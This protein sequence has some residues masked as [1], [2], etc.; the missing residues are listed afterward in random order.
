MPDYMAEL[1]K[2][3]TFVY[4]I[5]GLL[6][7]VL[8]FLQLPN[9]ISPE[10]SIKPI[11][12]SKFFAAM[13]NSLLQSRTYFLPSSILYQGETLLVDIENP[14]S[15]EQFINFQ[16]REIKF[17]PYQNRL[18]A[19]VALKINE[20]IGESEIKV[21]DELFSISVMKRDFSVIE[22]RPPKPLTPKLAA[23]RQAERKVTKQ[24]FAKVSSAVYFNSP[25]IA[26]LNRLIETS[27][28]GEHRVA[29]GYLSIHE[30]ID[31]RAGVGT[32]VRAINDGIVATAENYLFEGSFVI[33]DH[34][35]GI[36]SS[37][38]HL[39][40]LKVSAGEKIEKG[41]I[42]GLSGGSGLSSG[43][44]LHFGIKISGIP[45]DPMQFLSLW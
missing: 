12:E 20:S 3:K 43:P 17:F 22:I 42:I 4:I 10:Q 29:P 7:A 34:G 21:N 31:L 37:Y 33:L 6:V 23:R 30:G 44:H 27:P 25:F 35:L 41:Q 1:K 19:V 8:A 15:Q 9:V 18:T 32:L 38:L 13:Q 36:H 39:S 24:A 45:I 5:T 40:E 26:P 14:L 11:T 2:M 28:F 16:G